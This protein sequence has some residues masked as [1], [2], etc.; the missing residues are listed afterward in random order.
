MAERKVPPRSAFNLPPSWSRRPEDD[1]PVSQG[2]LLLLWLDSIPTV[3]NPARPL[4]AP[5]TAE[6]AEKVG[7][8]LSSRRGPAGTRAAAEAAGQRRL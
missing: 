2:E 4:N 5:L 1:G 7:E 6:E 8:Y 3:R